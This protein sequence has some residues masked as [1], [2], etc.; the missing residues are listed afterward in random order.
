[1]AAHA[2]LKNEFTEDEKYH[3]FMR[4]LKCLFLFFM[5]ALIKGDVRDRATCVTKITFSA[6]T[7]KLNPWKSIKFGIARPGVSRDRL[8][9]CAEIALCV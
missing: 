9:E 3:N 2:R 1:M 6:Y 5:A 8:S 4:W 7:D